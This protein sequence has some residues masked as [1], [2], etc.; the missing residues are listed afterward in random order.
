M[1]SFTLLVL[2]PQEDHRDTPDHDQHQ[3]GDDEVLGDEVQGDTEE[4]DSCGERVPRAHDRRIDH[5]L[6]LV[7]LV[8][9]GE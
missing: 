2:P 5:A 6:G 3:V 7:L 8:A 4:G 9:R 1:G